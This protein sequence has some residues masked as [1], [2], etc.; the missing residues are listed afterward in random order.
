MSVSMNNSQY[1]NASDLD[2]RYYTKDFSK[3]SDI[4][5]R[6]D[7]MLDNSL[8]IGSANS[9]N[10]RTQDT[11]VADLLGLGN[12]SNFCGSNSN[13]Y[14]LPSLNV[15]NGN[16]T[17]GMSYNTGSNMTY[18]P[19]QNNPLK[20]FNLGSLKTYDSPLSK[21]LSQNWSGAPSGMRAIRA[22]S[23]QMSFS[24]DCTS[25]F[26]QA[27]FLGCDGLRDNRSS[28]PTES[29]TS[30]ISSV[31]ELSS[32]SDLMNNLNL[33]TTVGTG[34]KV[35]SAPSL[36]VNVNRRPDDPVV[37][38]P[39]FLDRR[40]SVN[41]V[42]NANYGDLD[43]IERAARLYRNAAAFC[44]A[45]CTWS[46]HLPPR[47]Y[48]NPTY[49]CK[50]F[51]GGVP[52]DITEAGLI[53][54]FA[55]FGPIKILW[56]GKESRSASCPPK[57][58]YVYIIFEAEKHVKALLQA[59][60]HDYSNGGNWYFK[61]SSRRMRSKEVQVIPWVISD[62]NFVHCPSQ[63]LDPSKTVFVGALHGMLNAEGL[64]LVMNDLFGGV[65][66]AGI[67]TDK[68]KYPIGSGRI[69]FNN[70]KSY[71]KAVSAAF[72]EIKTPRFTKK[73]QVDPYLEDA[74]C[75]SCQIQQGPIF[76]RDASCFRYFCLSC[77]HWQHSV[78]TYR[79]HKP[80]MRNKSNR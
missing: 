41:S 20:T 44:E 79:N 46:G 72:I 67:D 74:I 54:A 38:S 11:T 30:G 80:L 7:A 73:V 77:W 62:S 8:D 27:L 3:N 25:S 71:M 35:T 36:N 55:P 64:A 33:G 21:L 14:G 6:I 29:D 15:P 42:L 2:D 45:N 78:D 59:C 24:S 9:I 68:Y 13:L 5:R 34:S 43:S 37:S 60:T 39:F 32:L 23:P 28:S 69:T 53:E 52:W 10:R 51:L 26:E 12:M 66:Y 76:C 1:F 48:K 40:W 50:V 17:N 22:A 49:S 70:H 63:R 75:S 57:A 65:V 58:G 16:I 61:I 18:S 19:T 31:S 56:P 47:T 4:Y